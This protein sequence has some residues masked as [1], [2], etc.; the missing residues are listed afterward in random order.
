VKRK[1]GHKFHCQN[2]KSLHHHYK[3]YQ[4]IRENGGWTN[5]EMKPIEEFPCKN[6]K[7]QLIREQY[8][9]DRLKPVMNSYVAHLKRIDKIKKMKAYRKANAKANAEKI[10][11]RRKTRYT[12]NCGSN[13]LL[14]DKALHERTMKHQAFIISS[15][16]EYKLS[17]V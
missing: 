6:K 3:I 12:C 10:K 1:Y 9:I 2:E 11:E 4:T 8:W 17:R 13:I 5:W 15:W 7:Q 16:L 14:N